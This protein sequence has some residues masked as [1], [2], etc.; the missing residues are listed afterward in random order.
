LQ[1]LLQPYTFGAQVAKGRQQASTFSK[2]GRPR[3]GAG[4]QPCLTWLKVLVHKSVLC[5]LEA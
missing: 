1:L 3:F 5:Y 4:K 2:L